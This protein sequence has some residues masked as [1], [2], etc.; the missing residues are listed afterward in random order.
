MKKKLHKNTFKT[1]VTL[2][3]IPICAL[4][5]IPLWT[6]IVASFSTDS[7]ITKYGYLLWPK[8][9]TLEGYS[10]IFAKPM[11]IL[12]AYGVTIFVTVVGTVIGVVVMGMF[13]YTTARRSFRLSKFLGY[14][15][16]LTMLF[17]GGVVPYYIMMTQYLHL[18]NSVW[19][20]ILPNLVGPFYIMILRTYYRSLPEGLYEAAK[21]DG[22]GEMYI[23]FKIAL[24]LSVPAIATVA[25]FS[26]LGFWNDMYQAL[27]FVENQDLYPLQYLLYRITYETGIIQEGAQTVGRTVPYQSVRMAMAMLAT[28]PIMFSFLFVQKYFVKG[29]TLG[30][31]KG[32]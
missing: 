27:L 2:A 6:L 28:L 22:A 31:M 4:C 12:R 7:D 16:F 29:I 19:A 1:V 11:Q 26:M 24:P 17:S 15:A 20:L 23:F 3:F 30:G 9:F 18:K 21:L 25:L 32:D 14:Y 10:Y 5:L 8:T 13:A